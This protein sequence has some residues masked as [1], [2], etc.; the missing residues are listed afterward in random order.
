MK[1]FDLKDGW[2]HPIV[3]DFDDYFDAD[4]SIGDKCEWLLSESEVRHI[5]EQIEALLAEPSS[6][7]EGLPEWFALTVDSDLVSLGRHETFCD[8]DEAAPMNTHWLFDEASLRNFQISIEQS[9]SV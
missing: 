2:L 6:G 4:K 9:L 7:A 8:A 1:F 3:G 5:S